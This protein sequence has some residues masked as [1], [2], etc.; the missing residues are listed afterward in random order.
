MHTALDMAGIT[1]SVCQVGGGWWGGGC[2][3]EGFQVESFDGVYYVSFAWLGESGSIVWKLR[4]RCFYKYLGAQRRKKQ[5]Y[6]VSQLKPD[7][8]VSSLSE[9]ISTNNN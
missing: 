4:Y 8:A 1:M 2:G 3:Q 9:V 6:R 7:Y 5:H